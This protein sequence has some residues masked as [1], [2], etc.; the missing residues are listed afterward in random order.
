MG[1][2]TL[3]WLASFLVQCIIIIAVIA[4][5]NVVLPLLSNWIAQIAPNLASALVAI[6][7]I[8]L[9]AGV[10]IFAIWVI[11]GLLS[12]L[13]SLGGGSLMPHFR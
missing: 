5:I 8:V 1:C 13:W 7:R 11:F 10:A 6:I 12:C 4:I 2:F 3:G 9:W